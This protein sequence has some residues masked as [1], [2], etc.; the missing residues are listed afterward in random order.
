MCTYNHNYAHHIL[1]NG[2]SAN[3]KHTAR[4]H[5]HRHQDNMRGLHQQMRHDVRRLLRVNQPLANL[6]RTV[7]FT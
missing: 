2:D 6:H 1:D 4:Y 5:Q 3:H 7:V